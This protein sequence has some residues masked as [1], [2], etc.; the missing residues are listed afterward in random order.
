MGFV[1]K[2]KEDYVYELDKAMYGLKQAP[3]AFSKHIATSFRDLNFV[4]ASSDECLWMFWSGA[5]YVYALY[6]VDD[7]LMVTNDVVL[8]AKMYD[9]LK[10][11][12]DIRDEG[13][14]DVFLGLKF[15]YGDDGTIELSQTHYIEKMAERFGVTASTKCEWTPG[16]PDIVLTHADLPVNAD[17]AIAAAKLRFPALV[18]SLI[19]AVKTRPDVA[20]AVSD[21]ARFMSKWGVAHYERAMNVL[22]YLYRTRAQNLKFKRRPGPLSMMAFCDANYGDVRET[23]VVNSDKWRSQGG[24]LI[25]ISGNLVA[26]SSKRHKCVTLSTM[27]AEYVEATSCGKEVIWFR[28]LLAELGHPQLSPTVIMEDNKAAISFSLNQ[29]CH[30]RSKHIDIRAHWLRQMVFDESVVLHH[31]ATDVQVADLMTKHLRRPQFEVYRDN[32]LDGIDP[33]QWRCKSVCSVLLTSCEPLSR[34]CI[35]GVECF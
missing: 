10:K 34:I 1:V 19:Y 27:E 6:H 8:R 35:D 29:T 24:Y 3:R 18:G 23:S 28:R 20:F 2:G 17:D 16:T 30:E 7:V 26:W 5:S 31:C 32:M 9:E 22:R 14:A 25:Y 15:V 13:K 33:E 11:T 21:V 4:Q 12:L